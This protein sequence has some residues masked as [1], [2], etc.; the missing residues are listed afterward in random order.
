MAVRVGWCDVTGHVGGA[1]S[2]HTLDDLPLR[3]FR[4]LRVGGE[5]ELA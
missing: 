3:A 1:A 4:R 5:G 2:N